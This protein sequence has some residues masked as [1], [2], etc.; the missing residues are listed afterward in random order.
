LGGRLDGDL[1]RS[2]RTV[3]L[4]STDLET[5]EFR[6]DF[7]APDLYSMHEMPDLFRIGDWWYLLTTEYSDRSKTIYRMSRS[8]HGPWSAP[9]D[10]AFDGRTYYAARTASDGDHRYLFGW[11]PTKEG[12]DDR[13]AQQ[14]GGTLV[15]HEVRQRADGSLGVAPAPGV[16]ARFAAGPNVVEESAATGPQGVVRLER[17]DGAASVRLTTEPGPAWQLTATL[18]ITD[19][20]RAVAVRFAEQDS[21]GDAYA[22][23]IR[24]GE[25]LISFDKVPNY[26][27]F[28]YDARGHDRPYLGAPGG[29]HRLRLIV[30]DDLATLYL[31]DVALDAR[32]HDRRGHDIGVEVVDGAATLR[33]VVINRWP[34][35]G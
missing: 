10:D 31:D 7:W 5:W 23:T 3:W 25:R 9:V 2:G 14:W 32:F 20:T 4:T 13:G 16:A 33:D 21:T 29:A 18:E 26:P 19:G 15:V 34:G 28:R 11:V 24:P 22:F 8:L 6:G 35:R 1:V 12:G 30:D 27:W 17:A